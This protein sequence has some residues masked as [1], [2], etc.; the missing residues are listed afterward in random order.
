MRTLSPQELEAQQRRAAKQ[1]KVLFFSATVFDHKLT[2]LQ[3]SEEGRKYRAFS[4]IDFQYFSGMGEIETADTIYTLMMALDSG[5]AETFAERTREF[6]QVALLPTDRV[7]WLPFEGFTPESTPVV[8]EWDSIHRFFDTHRE[9]MIRGYQQREAANAERERQ[10]RENP[11]ARKN[12]V[13]RYWRKTTPVAAP[14]NL[15][16]QQ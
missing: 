9:E 13:I 15:G 1:Q 16:A 7:A 5:T 11:P 8:T 2:E 14:Q 12:T 6:P 4:N 10:L 3:W